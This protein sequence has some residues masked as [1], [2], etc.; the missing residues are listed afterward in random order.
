MDTN[1]QDY[2]DDIGDRIEL[3]KSNL[4]N[5]LFTAISPKQKA[6]TLCNIFGHLDEI[7][8]DAVAMKTE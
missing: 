4:A 8:E 7:F 2:L 6:E 5:L 1:T 3:I